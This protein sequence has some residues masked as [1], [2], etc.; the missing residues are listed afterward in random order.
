MTT[1]NTN[2]DNLPRFY[3]VIVL[4]DGDTWEMVDNQSVCIIPE[5]QYS[6]LCKGKIDPGRLNPVVEFGL[7]NFTNYKDAPDPLA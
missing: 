4:A 1:V 2:T 6:L 7:R 5:E 3:A